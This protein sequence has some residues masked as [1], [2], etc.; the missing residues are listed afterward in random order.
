M[1]KS[2]NKNK[3]HI[4]SKMLW[5]VSIISLLYLTLQIF[6]ANV[7][8]MKYFVYIGVLFFVLIIIYLIFIKN[9]RTKKGILVVT[10]LF[11]IIISGIS[12]FASIEINTL[13]TFLEANLGAKYDT[14]IYYVIVNKDSKYNTLDDIKD[15]KVYLLNDINDK[16]TLERNIRK[17]MTV[18]LEYVTNMSELMYEV[19][20]DKEKILFVNSGN[21]DAMVEND[22]LLE[23]TVKFSE[24]TKKLDTI[25]I[26]FTLVNKETGI[27]VTEDPFLIYISGIDTRTDKLPTNSLSDVN[28]IMAVNPTTHQILMVNTPRDYFVQLHG[29]TGL[30]DKLTHAGLQGGYELS[31]STLND[32]YETDIKYY[33]RV[34]FNALTNLVDAIGG[35]TVYSDVNYSFKCN[36]TSCRI[37]PGYNDLDGYCALAFARERHAYITGDRHRGENQEQVISKIIEKLTSSKTLISSYTDILKALEGTFQTNITTNEITSLAKMQINSMPSWT[38]STHNV[39]GS[40]SK[41]KTY[42]YPNQELYVMI[43]NESDVEEVKVELNNFLVTE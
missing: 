22:T 4:L 33:V 3:K 30:K 11:F 37:K 2:K 26:S 7:L 21:Y 34:N 1:S 31:M 43:P 19:E 36:G 32:L 18:S 40:D 16:D 5:A 17:K 12:I 29:T 28:I 13:M 14:N 25:E 35:I 15:K 24:T 10:D 20:T 41:Q 39:T 38:I 42:S 27:D 23:S 8:P 9:K 6:N